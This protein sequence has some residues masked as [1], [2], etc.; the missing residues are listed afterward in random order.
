MAPSN[1][2]CPLAVILEIAP[3]TML[4]V[5]GKPVLWVNRG[6]TTR[7]PGLS[8]HEGRHVLEML[9]HHIE[10]TLV[11]QCRV[12]VGTG[13]DGVQVEPQHH[14]DEVAEFGHVAAVD[15]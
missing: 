8:H 2:W 4:T 14:V 1:A 3:E 5:T 7:I 15:R 9:F 10:T 11:A 12:R 6:F 13:V